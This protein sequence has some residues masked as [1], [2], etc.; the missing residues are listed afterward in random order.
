ML[1]PILL[2]LL[3]ATA[4]VPSFPRA[5]AMHGGAHLSVDPAL[6]SGDPG[7]MVAVSVLVSDVNDLLAYDVE[8]NYNTA[9]LSASCE[10]SL[11]TVFDGMSVFPVVSECNDATGIVRSARALLGGATKDVS[12]PEAIMYITFTVDQTLDSDLT[13]NTDSQLVAL[14]GGSATSVAYQKTDGQFLAP[15]T[16]GLHRWDASVSPSDRQKFLGSG[17]TSLTLV[18]TVRMQQ[19]ATRGGFAFIV[20][21]VIAPDGSLVGQVQ[22]NIVFVNPGEIKDVSAPYAFPPVAG[23][24]ELFATLWRGPSLDFF[25]PGD[26]VSGLHF[27]VNA[28]AEESP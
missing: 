11:G 6:S 28:G 9:A 4:I 3:A 21:D 8:L 14:V 20:F 12:S 18:G 15:P 27:F 19:L 1:S 5:N 7:Q 13:I 2:A 10:F 26:T 25:V 16:V 23:R 17:E 22:S 24:Y